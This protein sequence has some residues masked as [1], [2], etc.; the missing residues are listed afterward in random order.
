MKTYEN[1]FPFVC[2]SELIKFVRPSINYLLASKLRS[3]SFSKDDAHTTLYCRFEMFLQLY[4]L[5]AQP[6]RN[7]VVTYPKPRKTPRAR[8]PRLVLLNIIFIWYNL[9]VY[10]VLFI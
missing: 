10:D 2:F 8:L 5:H 1:Q 4:R 7:R 3:K 6:P 9:K